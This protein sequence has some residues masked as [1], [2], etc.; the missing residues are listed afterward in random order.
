MLKVL[1]SGLTVHPAWFT[2]HST[3]GLR[4]A[5]LKV[6]F[7]QREIP[8]ALTHKGCIYG[9]LD[10]G[11]SSGDAAKVNKRQLALI[12]LIRFLKNQQIHRLRF[13]ISH[14]G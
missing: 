10:L 8:I 2:L 5:L 9:E 3:A 6:C 13:L 1:S 14:L 12:H 11:F 7:P 4:R